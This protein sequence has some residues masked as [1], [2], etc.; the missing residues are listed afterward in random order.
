MSCCSKMVDNG[1]VK[2]GKLAIY[3][4]VR[5]GIIACDDEFPP[6]GRPPKTAV[7]IMDQI[8]YNVGRMYGIKEVQELMKENVEDRTK[9]LGLVPLQSDVVP[10]NQTVTN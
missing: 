6:D 1:Y 4:M 7:E 9:S 3:G 10:S 5:D 2:C 8:K